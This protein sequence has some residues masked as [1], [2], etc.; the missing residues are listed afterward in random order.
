ML[1]LRRIWRDRVNGE[2]WRKLAT[3]RLAPAGRFEG[4][5]EGDVGSCLIVEVRSFKMLQG[6][7]RS[8]LPLD[9]L[10]VDIHFFS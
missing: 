8:L 9:D 3:I 7:R 5:G 2:F 4:S 6:S 1:E 10:L